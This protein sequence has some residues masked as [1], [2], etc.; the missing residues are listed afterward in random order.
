MIGGVII[1]SINSKEFKE[2]VLKSNENVLVDFYADWCGPCRMLGPIIEEIAEDH[3][4]YKVNV[5]EEGELAAEYAVMSIPC[6]ISF[7]KG[8]E[9]KRSIGLTNKENLLKLFE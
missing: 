2:L 5:D 4:V 3:K 9:H 7:K 1:K 8:K 6:I